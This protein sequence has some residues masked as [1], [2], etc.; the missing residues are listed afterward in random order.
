M[1]KVRRSRAA[2]V[3][4]EF[5]TGF[6]DAAARRW[7]TARSRIAAHYL[8][9]WFWIDLLSIFPYDWVAPRGSGLGILQLARLVRLV[10]L[11][12]VCKAPRILRSIPAVATMSFKL[13]IILRYLGCLL[14]MLHLQACAIRLAHDF[15]RGAGANAETNS[16]LRWK[17]LV[18]RRTTFRSNWA[19]YVDALDWAVQTMLGQSAYMTTAEGVLSIV[20]N[21][22]G[23]GC[24]IGQLQR[25]VSRSSSTRFGYFFD[26]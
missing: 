6:F 25:L 24:D 10:K 7:V 23:K 3:A 22:A 21:R 26:E 11:L 8:R 14:A 13:K 18:F 1:A 9:L 2:Q 19:S 15:H 4:L 20:S 16:Y 5:N 17:A 12:R